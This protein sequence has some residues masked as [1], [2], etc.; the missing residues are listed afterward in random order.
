MFTLVFLQCGAETT[1]V[2]VEWV[3]SLTVQVTRA[4]TTRPEH[5]GRQD[6]MTAPGGAGHEVLIPT[7][8]PYLQAHRDSTTR[9]WQAQ[10]RAVLRGPDKD[11]FKLAKVMHSDAHA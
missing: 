10:L 4:R 6:V 7:L 3:P 5:N 9:C 2:L 8:T 1:V 11:V